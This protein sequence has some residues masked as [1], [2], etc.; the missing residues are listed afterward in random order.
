MQKKPTTALPYGNSALQ[1]NVHGM[2]QTKDPLMKGENATQ[3][4]FCRL[5]QWYFIALIKMFWTDNMKALKS[6]HPFR[7][8]G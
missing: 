1:N 7:F 4:A 5:R 2:T 3:K 6:L 8:W